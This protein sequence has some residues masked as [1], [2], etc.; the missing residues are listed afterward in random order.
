MANTAT[1]VRAARRPDFCKNETR[2]VEV[3]TD[4]QAGFDIAL[5]GVTSL[6]TEDVYLHDYVTGKDMPFLAVAPGETVADAV[7]LFGDEDDA[8]THECGRAVVNLGE[9][10]NVMTTAGGSPEVAAG[11]GNDTF[12]H[13]AA[14]APADTPYISLIEP[15]LVPEPGDNPALATYYGGAGNDSFTVT[16]D[17]MEAF[18]EE[19]D[20]VF[21]GALGSGYDVAFHGGSAVDVQFGQ[22]VFERDAGS[23][24]TLTITPEAM[25]DAQAGEEAGR[26]PIDAEIAVVVPAGTPGP[27][28]VVPNASDPFQNFGIRHYY[29]ID[30]NGVEL[31]RFVGGPATLFEPVPGTL[32]SNITVTTG[33]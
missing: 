23:E 1:T 33:P 30:G 28:A 20:D 18:G 17:H 32:P 14:D 6:A 13:E 27:F 9:G 7:N 16:G 26:L 31:A 5:P 12:L 22:D 3:E 10:S 19:G 11:A 4:A 29:L 15:V 2:S 8:V 25:I 21:V 24:V